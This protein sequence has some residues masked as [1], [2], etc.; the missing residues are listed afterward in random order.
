M[1]RPDFLNGEQVIY[2]EAKAPPKPA[3]GEPCNG[4]G[5]CC[6]LETCPLGR[7]CFQRKQGPCP[8]LLWDAAAGRYFCR[9][10][11]DPAEGLPWLKRWP[12][13]QRL[14]GKFVAR[15]IAAQQGCDCRVEIYPSESR[16]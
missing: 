15:S 16:R 10:L 4:C 5:V 13:L 6:A 12:F 14:V 11:K 1:T 7:L 2:L 3:S 8:G 9:L